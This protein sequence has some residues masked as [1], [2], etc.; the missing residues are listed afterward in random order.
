MSD[1]CA[2]LLGAS[3]SNVP[4]FGADRPVPVD[5][6]AGDRAIRRLELERRVVAL[7]HVAVPVDG[8]VERAEIDAVARNGGLTFGHGDEVFDEVGRVTLHVGCARPH[9]SAQFSRE[10]RA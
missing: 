3:P 4:S 1:G 2:G 7:G 10:R 5:R 8:V 9:R 6:E